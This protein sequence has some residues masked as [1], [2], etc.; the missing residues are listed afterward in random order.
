MELNFLV[1]EISDTGAPNTVVL[2]KE[3]GTGNESSLVGLICID[4]FKGHIFGGLIW[5][6]PFSSKII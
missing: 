5:Y 4:E 3:L 6:R 2:V 1:K